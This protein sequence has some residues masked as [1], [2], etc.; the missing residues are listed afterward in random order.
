MPRSLAPAGPSWGL[1]G[2]RRGRRAAGGILPAKQ[3]S[4]ACV[5]AVGTLGAAEKEQGGGWGCRRC[6]PVPPSRCPRPTA[7]W[8][9]HGWRRPGSW[10]SWSPVSPPGLS[11]NTAKAARALPFA[12]CSGCVPPCD[13]CASSPDPVSLRAWAPWAGPAPAP[14]HTRLPDV[15]SVRNVPNAPGTRPG[16]ASP[17]P[18]HGEAP[19]ARPRFPP[20]NRV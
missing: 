20:V 19:C 18:E 10:G 6:H 12:R 16:P 13:A 15:V 14:Q 3:G 7:S 2:P 8:R 9:G 4:L 5:L 17:S 1:R 11:A